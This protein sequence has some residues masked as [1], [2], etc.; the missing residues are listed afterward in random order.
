MTM[1]DGF[2]VFLLLFLWDMRSPDGDYLPPPLL[3]FLS[4]NKSFIAVVNK[5][6]G[7][8]LIYLIALFL[9][10]LLDFKHN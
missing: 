5:M 7:I 10:F 8:S 6:S 4:I 3:V 1:L 2:L 9:R